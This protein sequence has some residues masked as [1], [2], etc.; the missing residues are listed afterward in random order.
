MDRVL[1]ERSRQLILPPVE[2]SAAESQLP[3]GGDTEM[4]TPR[5]TP[6]RP[7]QSELKRQ[8]R[9]ERYEQ[10]VALFQSGQVASG[11]QSRSWS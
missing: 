5:P 9:M 6:A 4:D 7:K 3:T 8:R 11:D 1:E 10:V 2:D